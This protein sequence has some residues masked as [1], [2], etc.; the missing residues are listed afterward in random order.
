MRI[1]V[2]IASVL[3]FCLICAGLVHAQIGS[4]ISADGSAPNANAMLDVKSPTTGDGKGM[5]IPRV[6]E[7]QRTTAN[8]SLA[9]GLL[10]NSGELRGG[11]AQGLIVY[12]TDGAQ[13]LYFNTNSAAMPTWIYLGVIGNG[14]SVGRNV[15]GSDSGTALGCEANATYFGAAMGYGANGCWS[16]AAVGSMGNGANGGLAV[17]YGANGY[18]T[19]A[20]AGYNANAVTCGVALGATAN[21][22]N[23]GA[24]AGDSANGSIR[25]T[26]IGAL[27]NGYNNGVAAGYSADGYFSG[28][29][30]GYSANGIYSGAA[31]GVSANG[32]K[33]NVAIGAQ[34]NAQGGDQRIAIG[35]N[36]TN[37][38]DDTTRIRGHL[39]LD[40]GTGVWYRSTFGNGSWTA[41]AFEID[42]PLDPENKILRHFC[43]EG[44]QVWNVYAGNVQLVN[45]RA[46]V[47]LPDYYSALNLVGS[48]IYSLTVVDENTAEYH[49]VKVARKVSDNR[50][51]I[52]GTADVEIS[53]T[54]KVLRNDPGCLEDLRRRPVEQM[55]SEI[56]NSRTAE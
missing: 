15:N 29:A 28:V 36:V 53:W 4:S 6:T 24:V 20:A 51:V 45:G 35:Y 2:V 3:I 39:Y 37:N 13:G 56:P 55:K 34:A 33:T 42:H 7:A 26:V 16:G 50:F 11:A 5:L 47:Q 52:T 22:Y 8:A 14:I 48:E 17:G 9:G 38:L 54:I 18:W 41:K 44:P 27:A 40:G 19:G 21:G 46:V 43:L 10:N 49:Q 31:L 32:A 12:Q 1:F 25:G 23:F 30:V